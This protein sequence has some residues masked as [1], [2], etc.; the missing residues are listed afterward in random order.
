MIAADEGHT[1]VARIL[2]DRGANINAKND[3]GE[4]A[5]MIA[6]DEGHTVIAQ[7]L[8]DAGATE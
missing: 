5:L 2:L 3:D 7:L 1:V 6:A 4:T 8:R